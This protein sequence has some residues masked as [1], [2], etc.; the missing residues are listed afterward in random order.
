M[1]EIDSRHCSPNFLTQ[2]SFYAALNSAPNLFFIDVDIDKANDDGL[3][4]LE[5]AAEHTSVNTLAALLDLPFPIS[6][7]KITLSNDK[8]ALLK[9]SD[10]IGDTPLLIATKNGKKDNVDFFVKCVVDVNHKNLMG[11]RAIDLAWEESYYDIVLTLLKADST[12]PNIIEKPFKIESIIN[13]TNV[14]KELKTFLYDRN[15]LL[16]WIQDSIL[17]PNEKLNNKEIT[18]LIMN[19]NKIDNSQDKSEILHA[20]LNSEQYRI[21]AYLQFSGI[22]F[23]DGQEQAEHFNKLSISQK[24]KLQN[25]IDDYFVPIEDA[26]ILFLVSK[27]KS[28]SSRNRTPGEFKKQVEKWYRKLDEIDEIS[29]ILKVIAV[30]YSGLDDIIFDEGIKSVRCMCVHG[31]DTTKGITDY[32][33]GRISVGSKMEECELLVE[34]TTTYGY[35]KKTRALHL[36]AEGGYLDVVQCLV[37][38]GADVNVKSNDGKTVLHWAARS[39]LDVVRWLVE[40]GADVNVKSNDGK[41]VLHWAAQGNLHVVQWLVEHGK[42]NVEA[43]DNYGRTMLHWATQ[44]NL[45]VVQWLVEHGKANVEAT[46]N[47]GRTML[48]WATQGNLDVVQ[49]LVEHGK[50]N[51]EATDNYGRTMLHWATQGNLDVVQWLVEHGKAN[52]EATDNYGRTMLHWAAEWNN[53]DVVK[54]LVEHGKANVEATDNDGHTVLH[55]IAHMKKWDVVQWLVEHGKANVEATNNGGRT[56]LHQAAW[57][58]L[59]VVQWLV[60]HGKANVEATD[61]DGHTVLHY[62]AHMRKWD[63]VQWLVEHGKANVEAIDKYGKNVLHWAAQ[64]DKW[65]VVQWLVEHGADVNATD[66]DG[67]T[68]L[69]IAEEERHKKIT[70]YLLKKHSRIARPKIMPDS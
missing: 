4:T 46:D 10:Q 7:E 16:N 53:W 69:N 70:E 30:R 25:E 42:A 66:I 39:N 62:T 68:P 43:T 38:H 58:N 33:A 17:E 52:V 47:Y 27:S 32:S 8:A 20:A 45:D 23:K 14:P 2:D 19:Y 22:K 67:K 21:Y 12:F 55:Y 59:D 50:A 54:W 26:H 56:V 36:A 5:I 9:Q 64:M 37:E 29:A 1:V 3:R 44:G 28:A 11:K 13:D 6:N 48:H 18:D 61:N 49:W 60:E 40:H 35:V 51:V 57:G 34:A 63:V 15:K 65:D 41:T 24:I 31:S